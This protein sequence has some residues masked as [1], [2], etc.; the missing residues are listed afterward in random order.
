[1][2]FLTVK[3]YAE[4]RGCTER[5]IRQLISNNKIKV[6]EIDGIGGEAGRQYRIPLASLE[7]KYIRKWHRLHGVKKVIETPAPE[8]E[9][10]NVEEISEA[11]RLEIGQWIAILKGWQQ[12]RDSAGNKQQADEE[13]VT[14][15]AE[16]YPD[17]Q[18]SRRG[19]Y[20]K[21]EAWKHGGDAALLDKRG[22][23]GHHAKAIPDEVFEIF[24]YFYLDESKKSV[25]KCRELTELEIKQNQ[26]ELQKYLPL[27]SV[28]TFGRNIEKRIPVPVLKYYRRGEKA[29]RDECAPYIRRTYDD[30]AS[31]DI[32]VC[33]N[34]TFDVFVDD[35]ES[36]KPIRVYLT[37]FLD[38]RSRKMMGW[39]VT[40]APCSDATLYALRR[41]IERYGI[42]KRIYSDNGRE[43]LTRD[44]GGRGFR[45][46]A[47]ST[48]HE[49]MTILQNLDIE[50]RTAMVRNA[51][52][53]IIERAFREVKE[54]FSRL[55]VGYT[56]GTITERPERLK[57]LEKNAR[58]FT[59]I[60]E[61]AGYV[62][63]Y[64]E[65]YFNRQPHKGVGMGGRTP[66]EVY[67]ACLYEQRIATPEQLNL[68]MLRNSR[69][70]K[71][72]RHGVRLKLYDK[73]LYFNSDELLM[74]HIGEKVYFRYAPD[75]LAEVRIY[76]EQ[77]RFVCTAQQQGQLSY[78]ASKED[79]QEAMREV[80]GLEKAV[81]SY[82]KKKDIKTEDALNLILNEAAAR[83]QEDIPIDPKIIR[84]VNAPEEQSREEYADAIGAEAIDWSAALERFRRIKEGNDGDDV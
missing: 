52:A 16:S 57:K 15:L 35:G 22:K 59:A 78:Y 42:P 30:L 51:K 71:V 6:E 75:N 10:P 34:H 8:M 58:N 50:F 17:M 20:R 63:T 56:G 33:D 70:V 79:I 37:G 24:E 13:Y 74:N 45:R 81:K 12:Y 27:A 67:A 64:I 82:M 28:A 11:E 76:D 80:R 9:L 14:Y 5:Y 55:F 38:V 1:M 41:G 23:H 48:E 2:E 7:Q 43:F 84:L 68:M 69:M 66:D 61:F 83:L 53:K 62:D 4:L 39:Y 65:G 32:W 19:L 26:E 77:D 36:S 49:P 54:C 60:E 73:E 21:L 46:S 18:F 3:D 72:Q 47:V 40:N 31:N 29:F 25:T 44:I